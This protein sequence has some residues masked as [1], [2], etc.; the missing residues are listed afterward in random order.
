MGYPE[1]AVGLR[2]NAG[3]VETGVR[4][5]RDTGSPGTAGWSHG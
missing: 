5:C 3:R 2:C 1:C 4:I